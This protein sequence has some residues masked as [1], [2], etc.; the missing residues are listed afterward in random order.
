M[1]HCADAVVGA[2]LLRF[3]KPHEVF[4]ASKLYTPNS[5]KTRR[6]AET[7]FN[8]HVFLLELHCK[9]SVDKP[10]LTMLHCADTMVGVGVG[11][12]LPREVFYTPNSKKPVALLQ[13]VSLIWPWRCSTFTWVI[14]TIIDAV[15]FHF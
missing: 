5:K 1:L 8:V 4:Y 6:I 10:P 14:H 15:L 7:G 12:S 11:A 13:R 3:R 2:H 9:P